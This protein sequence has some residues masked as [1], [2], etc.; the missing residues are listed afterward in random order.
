MDIGCGSGISSQN[1]H[2]YGAS[3]VLGIDISER[4][5]SEAKKREIKGRLE[6]LNRDLMSPIEGT[7]DI[8]FGRAILHHIDYK[9]VLKSLYYSNLN[10]GGIMVFME[11]LGSNL[12]IRLSK[13]IVKSA[14]TPDEKPFFRQDLR[15]LRENFWNFE[16]YPIN[17]PSLVFGI[18]SSIIFSNP[19]NYLMRLSDKIN[20]W[21]GKKVRLLAPNF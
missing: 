11:P 21:L 2:F 17:Y 18:L 5:I 9:V 4:F 15:W 13:F 19:H 8:I 6:F 1:L 14:H 3:Y 12:L 16:M 7:Y 20:F 10:Y